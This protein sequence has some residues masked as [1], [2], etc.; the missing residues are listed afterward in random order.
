MDSALLDNQVRNDLSGAPAHL[1]MGV[2]EW[3]IAR[4]EIENQY[5]RYRPGPEVADLP[6]PAECS[7]GDSR[8]F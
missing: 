6:F 7:G 3:K 5:V 2:G 4:L 8:G 1:E